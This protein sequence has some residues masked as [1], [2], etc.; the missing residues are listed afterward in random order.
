MKFD[1][2]CD[3]SRHIENDNFQYMV[4]GGIWC[5]YE[6]RKEISSMIE[7]M[8]VAAKFAGELKWTKVNKKKLSLFKNIIRLFFTNDKLSFRCIVINKRDLKHELYNTEEGHE[9]FYYKMYYYMINKK[10][11]PP[12][13]YRI[14]LDYK[15]KDNAKK[16]SELQKII[17]HT[18]Y[19]FSNQIITLMQSVHSSQHPLL[20]LVDILIGAIGYEWNDLNNSPAKIELCEF[21]RKISGRGTL[22]I[23]TPYT[24]NK[25]EIFNI[26]LR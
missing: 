19:D 5:E 25:F 20:Q 14:F 10:I 8:R 17:G 9:E 22:K 23:T 1:V 24:E 16:I 13:K 15:G 6:H 26:T 18:Y 3:E 12:N 2:F 11:S 4:L 21:I 7:N